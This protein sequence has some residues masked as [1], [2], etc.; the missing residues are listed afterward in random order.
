MNIWPF[1]KREQNVVLFTEPPTKDKDFIVVYAEYFM[2][3]HNMYHEHIRAAD[4][5]VV[6]AKAAL[7]CHKR[8]SDF[9]STRFY[10]IEL[11]TLGV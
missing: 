2:D 1:K 9:N 4:R 8:K 11:S 5:E 6:E 3:G 7:H 10:I